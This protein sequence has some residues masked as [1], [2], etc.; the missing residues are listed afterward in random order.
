MQ[1]GPA[2]KFLCA[3]QRP[4]T[5]RLAND[6]NGTPRAKQGFGWGKFFKFYFYTEY[7]SQGN[8]EL[9]VVRDKVGR[10]PGELGVVVVVVVYLYS[11]SRSASN[12][13]SKSMDC[14]IFPSVL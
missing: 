5:A 9:L 4:P 12:A 11:A 7:L 3:V 13:L 10:P 2:T 1:C 6:L 14:D 8:Q